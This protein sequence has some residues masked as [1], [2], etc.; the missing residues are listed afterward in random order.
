[1]AVAA[2]APP[3]RGPGGAPA[4]RLAAVAARLDAT[5]LRGT[6]GRDRAVAA[7]LDAA[8]LRGT[9]ARDR[10]AAARLDAAAL[11]GSPAGDLVVWALY[12]A[13]PVGQRRGLEGVHLERVQVQ[14]QLVHDLAPDE[15]MMKVAP[16][17]DRSG[18]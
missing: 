17:I 18:N 11:P 7:R 8:A 13:L 5:A 1:M 3:G 15:R 6:A 14:P 12:G 10:A 9:T 2:T 4:L 16:P